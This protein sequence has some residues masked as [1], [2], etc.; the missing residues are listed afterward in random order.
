MVHCRT[1]EEPEPG[2][3]REPMGEED[4]VLSPREGRFGECMP[5]DEAEVHAQRGKKCGKCVVIANTVAT[6]AV[7]VVAASVG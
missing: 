6:A 4:E 3:E 7:V 2:G 1:S 5:M